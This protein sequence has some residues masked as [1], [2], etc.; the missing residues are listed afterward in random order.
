MS[1]IRELG[2]RV[3]AFAHGKA[4]GRGSGIKLDSPFAWVY[5]IRR[6]KVVRVEGFL[7]WD[8]ALEPAGLQE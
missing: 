7:N 8:E 2:D 5:T 3:V 1:E 6:G 4:Q